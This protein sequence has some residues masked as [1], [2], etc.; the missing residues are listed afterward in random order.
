MAEAARYAKHF[1]A[2]RIIHR[3][4]ASAMPGAEQ[5]VDGDEAMQINRNFFCIPVSRSC[6][7]KHGLALPTLHPGSILKYVGAG[8]AHVSVQRKFS[9]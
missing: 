9:S 1:G 7:R 8:D 4:D 2:I 6:R 3:G 5:V